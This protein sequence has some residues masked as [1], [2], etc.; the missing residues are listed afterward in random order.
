[1]VSNHDWGLLYEV[2]LNDAMVVEGTVV[3]ARAVAMM[4]AEVEEDEPSRE[5]MAAERTVAAEVAFEMAIMACAP[6]PVVTSSIFGGAMARLIELGD[7][8]DVVVE[9]EG[10]GG[11]P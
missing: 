9:M 1:M 7:F 6:W 4:V 8:G 10:E 11:R 2:V 5:R 3:V